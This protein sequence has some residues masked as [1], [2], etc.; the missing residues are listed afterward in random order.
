MSW[1]EL[2]AERKILDAQ[3]EGAFDN[4]PGK[5]QPLDLES[6]AR[7]PAE[8]RA[9]YRIMKESKILPDWI[10]LAKE[11]RQ[12]EEQWGRRVDTFARRREGAL[13]EAL[14]DA[15]PVR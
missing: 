15:S 7:V 3:E 8:L 11:I 6:D 14:K 12:R 9:A 5:G 10:Q 1:F 4:L 2:I 13:E